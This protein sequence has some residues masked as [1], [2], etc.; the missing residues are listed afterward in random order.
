M[1]SSLETG[2]SNCKKPVHHVTNKDA[3]NKSVDNSV[4]VTTAAPMDNGQ[5]SVATSS[6]YQYTIVE[7]GVTDHSLM[8]SA[9]DDKVSD[10]QRNAQCS[11]VN[12]AGV[13]EKNVITDMSWLEKN[14]LI[15]AL[16]NDWMTSDPSQSNIP[17]R[18]RRRNRKDVANVSSLKSPGVAVSVDQQESFGLES[19]GFAAKTTS[20]MKLNSNFTKGSGSA[21][22][23]PVESTSPK[24]IV[25]KSEVMQPSQ[26]KSVT[27]QGKKERNDAARGKRDKVVVHQVAKQIV[28]LPD[29]LVTGKLDEDELNKLELV[30]TEHVTDLTSSTGQTKTVTTTTTR[31]RR[32]PNNMSV[33]EVASQKKAKSNDTSGVY[34]KQP[35]ARSK[36]GKRSLPSSNSAAVQSLPEKQGKIAVLENLQLKAVESK[37]VVQGT[38]SVVEKT[39]SI[40]SS[41]TTKNIASAQKSENL[42]DLNHT[43]S[44]GK[45][46]I[47]TDKIA[48]SLLLSDPGLDSGKAVTNERM[49][50]PPKKARFR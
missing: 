31:F 45:Q 40:D 36:R 35:A 38:A 32:R 8:A 23:A 19:S 15:D 10:A 41:D 2:T 3:W 43:V 7:L 25:S 24:Q 16:D 29:P 9:V 46:V 11:E 28:E 44:I 21:S 34:T 12:K 39:K 14:V 48:K 13:E 27:S 37:S 1:Q 5:D 22:S 49:A 6:T 33:L 50:T 30:R 47:N 26:T 4:G 18:K 17:I 20:E 42:E